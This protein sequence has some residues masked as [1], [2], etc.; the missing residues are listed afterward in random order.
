MYRDRRWK[1]NVYHGTG[2]GELYDLEADPH[3]FDDLWDSPEHQAVKTD[4]LRRSFDAQVTVAM[5]Y[6]PPSV[7]PF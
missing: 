5:N 2:V 7:M 1:L 6:G 4:L 3:E